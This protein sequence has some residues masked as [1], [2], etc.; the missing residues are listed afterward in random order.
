VRN[1][2]LQGIIGCRKELAA[3]Q[4]VGDLDLFDGGFCAMRDLVVGSIIFLSVQG[5]IIL[6]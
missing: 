4:R 3:R 5:D 2:R 6:K 1:C